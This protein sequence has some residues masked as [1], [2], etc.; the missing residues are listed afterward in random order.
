MFL[1]DIIGVNLFNIIFVRFIMFLY[2]LVMFKLF[3]I[4]VGDRFMLNI[5]VEICKLLD[6][7]LMFL[8]LFLVI[9]LFNILFMVNIL[10]CFCFMIINFFFLFFFM[11]IYIGVMCVVVIYSVFDVFVIFWLLYGILYLVNV[12]EWGLGVGKRLDVNMFWLRFVVLIGL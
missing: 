6:I 5:I 11:F 7:N 10:F 4:G 12:L 1:D 9:I 3:F 2:N 8:V